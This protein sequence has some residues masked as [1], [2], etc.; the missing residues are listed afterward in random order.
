ML[1]NN[2]ATRMQ[3]LIGLPMECA[4][5]MLPTSH[6]YGSTSSRNISPLLDPMLRTFRVVRYVLQR[7][8]VRYGT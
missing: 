5:T 2:I 6:R 8:Y 7:N 1:I 3:G 4:Q